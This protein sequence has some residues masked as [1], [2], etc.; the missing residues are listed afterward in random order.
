MS[1]RERR[2]AA[3]KA[4]VDL[5]SRGTGTAAALYDA[6][7]SHMQA[8]RHLDA[9]LCCQQ[10]LAIDPNHADTL[11]LMGLLSFH[12]KQYDHAVEWISHAIRQQP[13]TDY[14]TN[15]GT[16]LANQGRHDEALRAYDKAVQLKPLD[17]DLWRNL[18]NILI[19][20]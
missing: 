9:Q 18:G 5:T 13:K 6:G 20:V 17:A 1:R 2:A 4:G 14:L 12:A 10:A 19:D 3:K 11:H 15:L 16:T 8:G 7:L